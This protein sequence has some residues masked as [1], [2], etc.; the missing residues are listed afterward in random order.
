VIRQRL[1]AAR[2]EEQ[3]AALLLAIG[4]VLMIGAIG[5]GLLAFITTSVGHRAP[6]DS[7]RNRQ[8]AADGAVEQAV[9]SLRTSLPAIGSVCPTYITSTAINGNTIR[10]DCQDARVLVAS[11]GVILEQRNFVFTACVS[12]GVA[13]TDSTSIVRA[14][15]N[16]EKSG[17]GAVTTT[18]V[19]S[20][21]VNQ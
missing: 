5:A 17:T 12:T 2:R 15:V 18:Y 16:F 8:Y 3:G 6:L 21:S 14:Q 10:V 11:Q 19:Q 9:A 13:C 20:W 1:R 4:F 7:I